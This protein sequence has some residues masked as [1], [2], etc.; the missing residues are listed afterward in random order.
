MCIRAFLNAT[1]LSFSLLFRQYGISVDTPTAFNYP[2]SALY[3]P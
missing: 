1:A 2:S 3:W